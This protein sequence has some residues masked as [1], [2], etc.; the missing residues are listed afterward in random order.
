MEKKDDIR[1]GES[2]D[3]RDLHEVLSQLRDG[4]NM[5]FYFTGNYH[6]IAPKA[7]SIQH[8]YGDSLARAV[9]R[10]NDAQVLQSMSRDEKRLFMYLGDLRE[11][12][13]CISLLECCTDVNEVALVAAG[14]VKRGV[15]QASTIRRSDFVERLLPF[16]KDIK[17]LKVSNVNAHLNRLMKQLNALEGVSDP[18]D[19]ADDDETK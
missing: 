16:C 2:I 15:V 4:N 18:E 1:S 12:H 10:Q 6:S 13:A 3:D 19:A 14:L 11:T 5:V 17:H 7:I 8:F 9:L